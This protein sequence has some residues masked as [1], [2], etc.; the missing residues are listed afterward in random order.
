MSS[1]FGGVHFS[2][3]SCDEL[4]KKRARQRLKVSPDRALAA[5]AFSV[6]RAAFNT[7]NHSSLFELVLNP[8]RLL[9]PFQLKKLS[10]Y[11]DWADVSTVASLAL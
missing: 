5:L 4:L 9:N 7:L 8:A 10:H 6:R 11:A 3:K 1:S 2:L